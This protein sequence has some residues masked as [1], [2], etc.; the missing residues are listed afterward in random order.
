MDARDR[1][2]HI[3]GTINFGQ[4]QRQLDSEF[5]N[6]VDETIERGGKISA[7]AMDGIDEDD[8][9][10]NFGKMW[11]LEDKAKEAGYVLNGGF[12]AKV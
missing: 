10:D 3:I 2:R 11:H 7:N 8:G 1:E 6:W 4:A 9:G 5:R 12:Y